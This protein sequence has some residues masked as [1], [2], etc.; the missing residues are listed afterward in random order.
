MAQTAVWDKGPWPEYQAFQS[1]VRQDSIIP[2]SLYFRLKSTGYFKNNEFDNPYLKGASLIGI[3]FEPSLEYHPDG[4][5]TIRAGAHLLKYHGEDTFDRYVPILTLQ[6]DATDHFTMIFGTINGTVNH[7]LIEP[8]QNF[9]KY[10][11]DNYENGLQLLWNYPQFRGDVWLNWEQ[12]LKQGDPFQEKFTAGV[13]SSFTLFER[14]K[15]KISAPFSTVFRHQGG[16]ID[17]TNLPATTK[18]NLVEGLRLGWTFENNFIKSVALT[19]N[20]VEFLEIHP[21]D[22]V[23]IPYGHG[24]YS[25]VFL[26]TKIGSFEAGYW[27][28]RNFVA[29]HGMPM[30]QSISQYDPLFLQSFRELLVLK[31]QFE[32]K[33][34]DFIKFAFRFEPYYHYD[35]GRLDH[36]WSL[37]MLFDDEFLLAKTKRR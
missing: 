20:Y 21:G 23:T 34:T 13:N 18:M 4:K 31:Y 22:F 9:E 14:G 11:V 32:L 36:S 1:P 3:Y 12:F 15:F 26:D 10:L 8:V 5:T 25:R 37:Y 19:Q 7:G 33:L 35:T 29:P 17:A 27:K 28:A 16:E 6:Y 2:K 30:F 24:S